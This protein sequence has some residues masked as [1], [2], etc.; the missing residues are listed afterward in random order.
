MG[1]FIYIN[2][3]DTIKQEHRACEGIGFVESGAQ[4]TPGQ[5]LQTQTQP[6][7]LVPHHALH[8]CFRL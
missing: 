3:V 5:F 6:C 4:F 2:G 7:R 1:E 8:F